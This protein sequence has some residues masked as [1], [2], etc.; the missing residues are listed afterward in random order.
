MKNKILLLL[1][2][3][4]IFIPS[5]VAIASYNKTKDEPVSSRNIRTLAIADL[6]GNE[7]NFSREDADG[8]EMIDFFLEMNDSSSKVAS[9][10]DPLIGTNFFKVT[11]K[12]VQRD[13][14][15]QYYFS[16]VASEA[17]F[18]N[19]VGEAYAIPEKYAA[20]FIES[21]YAVSLY[22]NAVVPTL[23]LSDT[24]SVKPD[25]AAWMYKNSAGVYVECDPELASGAQSVSLEGGLD[26]LFSLAPDH[27]NVKLTDTVTGNVIYNDL[28][29]NIHT[30]SMDK[31]VV[32]NVEI[33]A[34]WYEDSNR[35][36]H[37][38]MH[39]AFT[40]DIAAPAQF[41]LAHSELDIGRAFTTITAKNIKDVEKIQFSSAPDIGYSPV[42]FMDGDYAVALLPI[43]INNSAGEYTL[44][45]KYGGVTED[46]KL[47]VKER[48]IR[49][50]DYDIQTSILNAT[51]TEKTQ[52]DFKA[53]MASVV[54]KDSGSA[55]ILWEGMFLEPVEKVNSYNGVITTGFG[56][57]RK[58]KASGESYIH[59]GV[60]Y[61]R[62]TGGE[63]FACNTGIVQYAGYTELGGNTIVIE[64]GYGLKTWYCHLS[65]LKVAVGDS[66]TKGDV[67]GIVGK[68]GF[69]NQNGV[70][71]GMS[72]FDVAVS[73]Y[74]VQ[75]DEEIKFV[76][77]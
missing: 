21:R 16:T 66:V 51:R 26:M 30:L 73:P 12:S 57:S 38:E 3:V 4:A 29:Q 74:G 76:K 2:A 31:S 50:F 32:L 37:G 46:L 43:P 19:D 41:W 40:A 11:M 10:P 60:D 62:T 47:T 42:F 22:V 7:F 44:T 17:Y 77:E 20:A 9:L 72:I 23:T 58:I 56:H 1:C 64:H 27:F 67:I 69:T 75:F 34:K 14:Q 35:D 71:V 70:H 45:F 25:T 61:L 15:Y 28:Y 6:A 24:V 49:Y 13:A 52:A 65:E 18:L 53:A 33:D 5:V 55:Q 63:V 68:T 8:S 39:Y 54:A 59:E 48:T 36:Y